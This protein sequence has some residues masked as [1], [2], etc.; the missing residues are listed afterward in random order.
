MIKTQPALFLGIDLG[1]SGVR[2]LAATA[3]GEVAARTSVALAKAAGGQQA[4]RHEQAPASWWTAVCEATQQMM[5]DLGGQGISADVLQALAVDGTSGTLVCV[6]AGGTPLRPA[7]MYNDGRATD[8][9]A[10]INAVAGSFCAKLGYRFSASYALAKAL[11]ILHHEPAVF[12]QTTRF[13]HQADLVAGRLTGRFDVSD[14]SNAL[15]MGY[16]LHEET[17]PAWPARWAGVTERLPEVVPPGTCIGTVTPQAAQET[18]LPAGLPIIA[19]ATDG[20]ASCIAS[21]V[22]KP[23]DYNTTL[24]TTLVFKS[25]SK[26]LCTDP[27]GRIYSHKLPGGVWLPGGA[28]NTGAAW[29]PA[30]FAGA[31]PAALDTQAAGLLPTTD[32]AYPLVGRGERF[33]FLHAAAEGFVMPETEGP[34]RYAAC[35]Q[36]TALVERLGYAVLD[37]LTGH[38][39]GAVYSTG[40]GSR[41]DVWMQCRADACGRLFHR[42]ACPEAAMGAAI[43][44]ASGTALGS[45]DA[46]MQSMTQ[47][48]RTFAPQPDRTA[49]YDAAYQRF[50]AALKEKGYGL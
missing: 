16:D 37:A 33:P 8:E 41:S 49:A 15:K 6:D 3:S 18:G 9:A 45:L 38:T 36:G 34:E 4:G 10:T 11:W 20:V 28:S 12:E 22:R 14:Y 46:A 2:V 50:L 7:L 25:I 5:Q 44:A 31:D 42:P 43:L 21:G 24:G 23:G 1:T 35:L 26:T 48:A 47:I 32:L 27:K 29:I 17:W 40:G 30:W 19:G 39:H 13:L